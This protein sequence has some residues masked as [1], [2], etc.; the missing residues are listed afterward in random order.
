M[1]CAHAC[2]VLVAGACCEDGVIVQYDEAGL[3]GLGSSLAGI[4]PSRCAEGEW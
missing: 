1:V 4:K 3:L 2:M